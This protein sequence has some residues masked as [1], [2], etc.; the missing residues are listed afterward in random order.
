MSTLIRRLAAMLALLLSLACAMAPMAWAES[1]VL[2]D[3]MADPEAP[4]PFA[5][6][7]ELLEVWFPQMIDC[8][9][10]LIRC[11]GEDVLI[12]CASK[13]YAKRLL[14]LLDGLGISAIRTIYNTHPHHDHLLGF[15]QVAAHVAV[16]E[17]AVCFPE[18]ENE[19]MVEALQ[20]AQA[21]GVPVTHY[22]DG[23]ILRVGGAEITVFLRG[24]PEWSVNNRSAMMRL[25]F[26]QRVML[27]TADMEKQALIRA[28][29]DIDPAL[30]KADIMKYP[31]HGLT[32]LSDEFAAAVSPL[33]C[34]VTNNLRPSKTYYDLRLRKLAYTITSRGYTHL[35]TDGETWLAEIIPAEEML[36]AQQ[37]YLAD[38]QSVATWS[39]SK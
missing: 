23:D 33:L 38:H 32:L 36:A 34:V 19:R 18:D 20:A 14:T 13:A 29:E 11:G 15:D 10:A 22:A 3:R 28:V 6:D 8:D 24:D 31:H 16:G 5:E 27:F 35:V 21:R 37:A 39:P 26:G 12:D 30:L 1:P 7:A 9:A 17:L 2:V 25:Q 4:W